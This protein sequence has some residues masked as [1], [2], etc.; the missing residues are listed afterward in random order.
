MAK[1][2][3]EKMD[4]V[5]APP[6]VAAVAAAQGT[7]KVQA[8]NTL[9]AARAGWR[10]L[11]FA[12]ATGV[13]DHVVANLEVVGVRTRGDVAAAASGSTPA[14]PPGPHVHAIELTAQQS[15]LTFVQSNDGTGRVR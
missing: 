13:V 3:Y 10:R 1:S 8:Q 12:I 5:L 7:A 6:F 4:E 2:I 14:V 15:G 9:D 11:S